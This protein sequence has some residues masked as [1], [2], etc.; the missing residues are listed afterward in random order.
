MS[1]DTHKH[2]LRQHTHKGAETS[3]QSSRQHV[4]HINAHTCTDSRDTCAAHTTRRWTRVTCIGPIAPRSPLTGL[5][6]E[7]GHCP[8]LGPR[9]L[10]HNSGSPRRVATACD[11]SR[12]HVSLAA[13]RCA[14]CA[15]PLGLRIT[16]SRLQLLRRF[17]SRLWRPV[18]CARSSPSPAAWPQASAA[19]PPASRAPLLGWPRSRPGASRAC[20]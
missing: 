3:S 10:L 4:S 18:P 1:T 7:H 8:R 6:S 11:T 2:T 9:A 20:R 5:C 16:E 15:S 12:T 19:R 17:L 13:P 14:A